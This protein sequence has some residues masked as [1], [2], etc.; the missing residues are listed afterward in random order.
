MR[1]SLRLG[2]AL[3]LT[4]ATSSIIQ[5]CRSEHTCGS[6]GSGINACK[7]GEIVVKSAKVRKPLFYAS[8]EAI[9]EAAAA[10]EAV[11]RLSVGSGPWQS[12]S[13]SYTTSGAFSSSSSSSSSR[14]S[15]SG[16]SL[17]VGNARSLPFNFVSDRVTSSCGCGKGTS[18]SLE[19]RDLLSSNVEGKVVPSFP[20]IGDLCYPSQPNSYK[21]QLTTK[22]TPAY[23]GKVKCAPPIPYKVCVK[24]LNGQVDEA[25]LREL[26]YGRGYTGANAGSIAYSSAGI[27]RSDVATSNNVE[28]YQG[29]TRSSCDFGDD[30]EVPEDYSYPG[31]P[32]DPVSVT[33]AYKNLFPRTVYYNKKT[34]VPEDKLAFGHRT[35]PTEATV[36]KFVPD[37]PEE[38]LQILEK[39]VV[40]L[41]EVPQAPVTVGTYDEHE[42]AKLAE[43][44]AI[45]RERINREEIA[46]QQRGNFITYGDLGYAPINR[47]LP[48]NSAGE[49]N[50]VED[51]AGADCGPTGPPDPDYV[52]GSVVINREEIVR[53]GHRVDDDSLRNDRSDVDRTDVDRHYDGISDDDEEY[54]S[55]ESASGI[56][57]RLKNIARKHHHSSPSSCKCRDI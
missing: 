46:E 52:P 51:D 1:S 48:V 13:K 45:E 11:G 33:L 32:A 57:A 7:C 31:L 8:P 23:P 47:P 4:I 30:A 9:N 44:E 54:D 24:V 19:V 42:Q 29:S 3:L 53:N 43:L 40:E 34:F 5:S 2:V 38:K 12:E 55:G 17:G 6:L 14:S 50:N 25:G 20:P 15:S 10:R 26:G 49:F 28:T 27:R 22:V 41:K 35:V 16:G 18:E 21:Y 39:P 36:S 56:F 37:I